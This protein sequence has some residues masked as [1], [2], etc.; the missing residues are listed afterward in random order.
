MEK[1]IEI[2]RNI[3]KT[4]LAI[5]VLAIFAVIFAFSNQNAI[6][7]TSIS[8]KITEKVTENIKQ[9]QE[10]EK[11]E[12]EEALLKVEVFIRKLAHFSIYLLVGFVV[13]LLMEIYNM[14][15]RNKILCSFGLGFLYATLDEIHQLFVPGR[16]GR[17]T[18]VFIDSCGV[19][20]GIG[21][22]LLILF[23]WHKLITKNRKK[24]FTK[25]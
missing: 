2:K 9:I 3:I 18:D 4:I 16:S 10:L 24:V 12:R 6:Q 15:L 19:V 23:L 20:V 7:S 13:M 21:I 11:E 22:A 1:Q 25:Q 14:K 17:I 5:L 8:R